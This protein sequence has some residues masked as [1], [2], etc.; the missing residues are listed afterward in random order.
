MLLL[1]TQITTTAHSTPPFFYQLF[2]DN[3]VDDS[4]TLAVVEIIAAILLDLV[5]VNFREF[6][7]F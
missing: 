3:V 4:Q 5:I 7:L 6:I 1:A 2:E